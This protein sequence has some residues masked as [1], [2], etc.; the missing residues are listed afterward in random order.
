LAGGAGA[1]RLA[2]GLDRDTVR[3]GG[4]NDLVAGNAGRDRLAGGPGRDRATYASASRGIRADL[5]AGTARGHGGDS[6]AGVDGLIGSR[7]ADT[8]IG[9]AGP[10]LLR[11]SVGPDALL[12]RGGRDAINGGGGT[13]GCV[14]GVGGGMKRDCEVV[15]FA[16]VHS[17]LVFEPHRRTVG[18]GFHEALHGA[19]LV[20]HPLGRLRLNDNRSRY[21]HPPPATDGPAYVVMGSRGRPT[22]PTSAIDLVVPSSARMR[23]PVSGTVVEVDTYLLY[24]RI[25]DWKVIIRPRSHPDLRVLV[26]HLA[27]PLVRKGDTV[28]AGAS[29]IGISAQND[30][31]WAQENDYFPDRY[32]HVH[33][34]IERKDARK[35][36]CAA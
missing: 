2:G 13:D 35:P 3:G 34:E 26:L 22:H 27:R 19:S 12:G 9:G 16:Q 33:V 36:P 18:F 15:A 17:L 10:N 23:A 1:D 11:G 4:G 29:A 21:P 31:S 20:L 30:A 6:L 28:V 32:P 25:R 14:Q 24:C 7:F 5:G 8:L